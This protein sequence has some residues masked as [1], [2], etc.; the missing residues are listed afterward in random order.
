MKLLAVLYSVVIACTASWAWI[1]HLAFNGS[2][3]EHLLPA[4]AL[5]FVALPSSLVMESL[6]GANPWLMDRPAAILVVLTGIGF[7]QAACVWLLAAK[8]KDS[9]H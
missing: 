6:V 8:R 9:E 4:V 3:R 2:S 5:N 1:D 7:L